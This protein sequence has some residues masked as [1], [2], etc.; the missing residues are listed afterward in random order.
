MGCAGAEGTQYVNENGVVFL[1]FV[2][3]FFLVDLVLARLKPSSTCYFLL[4]SRSGL[5]ST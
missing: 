4:H 3:V 1:F 2:F 5:K